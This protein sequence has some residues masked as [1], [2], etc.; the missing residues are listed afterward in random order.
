MVARIMLLLIVV[1]SR[2]ATADV[3]GWEDEVVYVVIPAKFYDGDPSNN[4]MAAR[5]GRERAKYQGGYWGGDLQGVTSKLDDLTDLGITTIL[6]YPVMQNDEAPAGMF[7]AGGYRPKDYESVDKNLGDIKDLRTLID[8]AHARNIRVIL[9]MPIALP[10][11]EHPFVIDPSK[12]DWFGEPT[13]YGM[14]RWKPENPAVADY[15][16]GVC[17]RWRTR[18]GCDGFRIDSAQLLPTAFLKR[19]VPEVK[20]GP[21]PPLGPFTVVAELAIPPRDIG[22]TMSEVGFDGAYDFSAMTCRDVF[23]RDEAVTKLSFVAGE[24]KQ[25]YP[26]PRALMAPIDNYEDTFLSFAKEPKAA[27]SWPALAFI[28]TTDRVP[29][30]YSGNELGIE[31]RDVGGVFPNGRK[32][33]PF[34]KKARTLIALRNKEPALRRGDFA[35]VVAHDSIYAFVR[36]LGGSRILIVLNGSNESKD[37]RFPVGDLSWKDCQLTDLVGGVF[38]KV[39]GNDDTLTVEPYG[40]CVAKLE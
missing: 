14:R 22:K 7:L 23:G 37:V 28:L 38:T 30:L 34:Y 25:Y 13:A 2:F 8:T 29:L 9:D 15:L 5:F 1:A 24:A 6:L 20:K 35:E 40:V 3:R 31:S 21:P 36:Q 32:D 39:K 18:S 19:F 11:F 33:S 16:I 17:Q 12:T 10:G 4:F 27:R 26:H